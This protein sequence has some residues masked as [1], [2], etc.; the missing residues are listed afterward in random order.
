VP[1]RV[2]ESLVLRTYPLK[3]ADLV[4]SFF[5]RDQGVLRGVARRARRPKSVFGAGLER[6]SHVRMTYFQRETRELVNLDSCELIQ[7]Q[8]ELASDY[9]ASVAL[10]FLAE[11]SGELLP[12]AEPGEK[13]F[14]LLLAVLEALRKDRAAGPWCAVTYFSYWAARLSGWLP[15]LDVCLGCG[16]LL[17]DAEAPERAY[18]SRGRPGL[19]CGHCRLASGAAGTWELSAESRAVAREIARR[20][21]AQVAAA[22]WTQ[23]TAADLRRFLVTQIE[24]HVERKLVTVSLLEAG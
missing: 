19:M 3:E 16:S 7:S 18:F 10:D 24:S 11:V 20:P 21:I 2:S 23:Q 6:L 15:E 14:R 12:S 4:V 1:A 8:F 13:F 5:T 17:D 9:R 22:G